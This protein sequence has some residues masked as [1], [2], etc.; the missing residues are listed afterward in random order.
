VTTLTGQS[1][2][3]LVTGATGRY[4]GFQQ[5]MFSGKQM[6]VLEMIR[7]FWPLISIFKF[8]TFLTYGGLV[9]A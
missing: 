3:R 5:D 8:G 7:L 6:L 9:N 1:A 2:C 4:R